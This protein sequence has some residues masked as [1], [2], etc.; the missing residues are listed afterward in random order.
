MVSD[1]LCGSDI[2]IYTLVVKV[3]CVEEFLLKISVE[4]FCFFSSKRRH[5]ICALVTGVQTCALPIWG[6]SCLPWRRTRPGH[7]PTAA[8]RRHRPAHRC[9]PGPCAEIGRASC[10]ERVCQYV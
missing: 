10:R 9:G 5:T 4:L 6:G 3:S 2:V 7:R 8:A 1:Q